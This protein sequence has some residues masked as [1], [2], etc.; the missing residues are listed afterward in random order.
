MITLVNKNMKL[1]N[2][3]LQLAETVRQVKHLLD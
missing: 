2:T 1:H 3:K